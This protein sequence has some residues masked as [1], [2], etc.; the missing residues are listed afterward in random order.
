MSGLPTVTVK[1]DDGTATFPYDISSY[2]RLVDGINMTHGRQDELGEI[3]PGTLGLT[4]DNTDGRFSLG[5]TIINATS[6]I[7]VDNQIRVT[8][9]V[10][11]VA[12]DRFT[13]YVQTWPV[14]WPDG[15]DTFAVAQITAVD[16]LARLSRQTLR[17]VIEEEYLLD[18]P[19]C[20]FTLGEPSG[21]SSAGD[22]SGKGTAPLNVS[23]NGAAVVFGNATGPSTDALT[24]VTF[25]AGKYLRNAGRPLDF[26]IAQ[27]FTLEAFVNTSTA[28]DGAVIALLDQGAGIIHTLELTSTGKLRAKTPLYTLT[29]TTTITNGATHHVALKQTDTQYKLFVDGVVEA[30]QATNGWYDPFARLYVGGFLENWI[31]WAPLTGTV[32]HVAVSSSLF[33]EVSDARIA[34]HSDAG[35]NGF[36]TE[37]SD[38]RISRYLGYAGITSANIVAETGNQTLVPHYDITGQSPASATATVNTAEAGLVFVSGDGKIVV[39]NRRHRTVKLAADWSLTA[40]DIA[41]STTIPADMQQVANVGTASLQG[42]ATQSV[43][44]ASS[45]TRHGAYPTSYDSLLVT[46]DQQALDRINWQVGTHAEPS[47]RYSSLQV[48]L[49]TASQ[50]LQ[51]AA[52]AREIGD[53]IAITGLPSQTPSALSD[54]VIEGWT[55]TLTATDWSM[56]FNTSPW[57]LEQAWILGDSIYGVLGTTTRLGF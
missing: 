24:A 9:T 4:L 40:I 25:A 39:H 27:F 56:T 1:L 34:A 49:L 20:Y 15:G 48:D 8:Y 17:S 50:T 7:Y 43:T 5:S 54:Q 29:G 51:Q 12:K 31:Q 13:G 41:P 44:N 26:S 35:L 11:G 45:K 10:G 3:Q 14:E 36:N 22:T 37:R 32:A 21:S 2:V 52:Q 47:P 33:N 16:R 53:R 38:Q 46:T 57:S 55:E 23:G 18:D 28:T 6:P 42:G 30:T 19:V